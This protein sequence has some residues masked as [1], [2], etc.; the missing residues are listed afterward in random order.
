MQCGKPATNPR[1]AGKVDQPSENGRPRNF[2]PLD[3][4]KVKDDLCHVLIGALV[5]HALEDHVE[6]VIAENWSD[7][8]D[9]QHPV[10]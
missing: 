9:S 4:A 6:F 5:C 1:A 10:C 8:T 3:R 7:G 2:D